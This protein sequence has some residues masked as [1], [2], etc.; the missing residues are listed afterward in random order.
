MTGCAVVITTETRESVATLT[1]S[2]RLM[3]DES[4]LGLREHIAVLRDAGIKRYV[5]DMSNVPHCDSSG[6]G[7]MISAYASIRKSGGAAAFI[8]PSERVRIIWTRIRLTDVFP[9]FDTWAEADAYVRGLS[10]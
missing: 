9:I 5:F 10:V 7:E 8:R 2:G 1:L 6:C 3:F 4:L